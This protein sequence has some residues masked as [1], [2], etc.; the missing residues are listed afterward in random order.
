MFVYELS[1]CGFES[2]FSHSYYCH[3]NHYTFCIQLC[4]LSWIIYYKG[5]AKLFKFFCES[6]HVVWKLLLK[7]GE[8]SWWLAYENSRALKFRC[9][10][11]NFR[12][13]Y[14]P[15]T[16]VA[17][18]VSQTNH[19]AISYWRKN[20]GSCNQWTASTHN[21]TILPGTVYFMDVPSTINQS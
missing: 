18:I 12:A 20:L 15:T 17:P 6:T 21:R 13:T 9:S 14:L 10:F 7:I 4:Q 1:G 16:K 3:I 8:S 2:R 19:S 11:C 5:V